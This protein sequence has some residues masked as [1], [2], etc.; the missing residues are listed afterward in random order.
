MIGHYLRVKVTYV[1]GD[2]LDE[3][4]EFVGQVT[5]VTPMVTVT[6]TGGE[7]PFTLPPN[8]KSFSPVPRSPFALDS[9][10]ESLFAPRYQTTWKVKAHAGA[11][12]NPKAG[13][14]VKRAPPPK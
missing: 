14:F 11:A 5:A 12:A 7:K 13:P 1:H 6:R 10:G 2:G 3:H 4:I 8:P 9:W